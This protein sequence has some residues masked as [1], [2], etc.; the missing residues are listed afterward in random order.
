MEVQLTMRVQIPDRV[1][2]L[3]RKMLIGDL[4]VTW[5]ALVEDTLHEELD[6]PLHETHHYIGD[7]S[8]TEIKEEV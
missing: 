5:R 1:S 7:Y 3:K 8:V 2:P 4:I 6:I